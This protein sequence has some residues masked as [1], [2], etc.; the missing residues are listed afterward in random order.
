MTPSPNPQRR[1]ASDDGATRDRLLAA[2]RTIIAAD[3]V[4]AASSRRISDAAGVNLAAIT[5]YF[6]SKRALVAASL[7]AE[8][9]RLSEPAIVALE[10]DGDGVGRLLDAVQLLLAAFA[11]EQDRAPA[12]LEALLDA[13][14]GHAGAEATRE[15]VAR[16]RDRLAAV[17][18]MLQEQGDVPAWVHPESMASLVISVANGIVLQTAVD[19]D[20]PSAAAQAAQFAQLLLIARGSS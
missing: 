6:G 9:E 1:A 5:Y 4:A 10:S 12:Y 7:V 16:L 18:A 14:H 11:E 3:G 13:A 20:G 8:V 2:T 19:P 17:V 15:L